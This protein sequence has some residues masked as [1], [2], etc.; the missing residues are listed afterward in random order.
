MKAGTFKKQF[1]LAGLLFCGAQ[2]LALRAG[3]PAVE[4]KADFVFHGPVALTG[5]VDA[6]GKQKVKVLVFF[7]TQE[8]GSRE[9]MNH[10]FDLKVRYPNAEFVALTPDSKRMAQAFFGVYSHRK[11]AGAADLDLQSSR[12]YLSGNMVYPYAFLIGPDGVIRWDGE[13]AD[14]ADALEKSFRGRLDV[15]KQRELSPLLAELRSRFRNGEERMAHFAAGRIFEIDPANSEAIRLR[16]FMLQGAGRFRD[17]WELL[18]A[19]RK[20]VPGAGKLYFQQIE[21]ACRIAGYDA[22][23]VPVA[24]A[25]LQNIPADSAGDGALAWLLLERRPFDSA[26]LRTAGQLI[27][28]SMETVLKGDQPPALGDADLYSAAALY[29]YR[30]GKVDRA[31]ELQKKATSILEKL[32]LH[33][34]GFSRNME[35]YYQSIRTMTGKK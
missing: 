15:E 32:A 17:A 20:E 22:Q 16:L 8:E 1:L 28:R 6:A 23:A 10:L 24:Q 14:L 18:E 25:Y 12:A 26:A 13:A 4:L 29:A 11:F 33:R 2:L 35:Q 7:R 34:V 9:L 3:D 30:L 21:L 31:W 19:R 5:A 27:G